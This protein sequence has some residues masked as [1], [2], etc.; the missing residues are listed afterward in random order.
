M[1]KNIIK[2]PFFVL[3]NLLNLLTI[4][5]SLMIYSSLYNWVPWH[6]SCG[7]QFM[8]IFVISIPA[9]III[10]IAII[11]LG[12]FL[13]ISLFNKL[14]PF[15]ALAVFVLPTVDGGLRGLNIMVGNILGL[16][17]LILT[18]ISATRNLISINKVKINSI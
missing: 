5:F 2:Q 10:G 7:M 13:K 16:I 1:M 9:F 17:L 18:I 12:F 8:A 4:I 14:L 11:V 15:I 3:L 6:E